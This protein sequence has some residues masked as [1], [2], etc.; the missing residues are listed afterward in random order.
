VQL[1]RDGLVRAWRGNEPTA[2]MACAMATSRIAAIRG[3]YA[4]RAGTLTG[5]GDALL[6]RVEAEAEALRVNAAREAQEAV[7]GAVFDLAPELAESR[8]RFEALAAEATAS[9]KGYATVPRPVMPGPVDGEVMLGGEG[10]MWPCGASYEFPEGFPERWRAWGAEYAAILSA[11]PVL[12]LR[13][14]LLRVDPTTDLTQWTK[15]RHLWIERWI[16]GEDDACPFR[17]HPLG[18]RQVVRESMRGM[19]EACG[20]WPFKWYHPVEAAA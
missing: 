5:E 4:A 8:A 20:G 2:L 7:T 9:L 3:S 6:P 17:I 13:D 10:G 11:N 19:L 16:K 15:N 1:V 12:A 18:R 14:A